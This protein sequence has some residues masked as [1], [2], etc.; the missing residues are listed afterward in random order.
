MVSTDKPV[1]S[2]KQAGM[3]TP[4]GTLALIVWWLN[5]WDQVDPDQFTKEEH[6]NS[7]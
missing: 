5:Y 3:Q 6:L 2:E 4:A 1:R 7:A